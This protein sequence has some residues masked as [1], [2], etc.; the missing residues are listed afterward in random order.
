LGNPLRRRVRISCINMPDKARCEEIHGNFGWE[1]S[2][3]IVWALIFG[4]SQSESFLPRKLVTTAQENVDRFQKW[5]RERYKT[6]I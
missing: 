3:V 5:F 4:I 1:Y 2:S 6:S